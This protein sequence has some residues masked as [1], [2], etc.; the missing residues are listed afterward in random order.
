MKRAEKCK[1]IE[2]IRECIDELDKSIIKLLGIRSVFVKNAAQFKKTEEDIRAKNRVES[3]IARR[4]DWALEY[5][6]DP[7][8]IESLYRNIVAF[9]IGKEIKQWGRVENVS[10]EIQI[11]LADQ[12]DAN[13]ILSLQKRAYL[14]EVELNDNNFNIPPIQQDLES[15]KNDFRSNTVL[16]A[17]SGD[18]IVGSVR[19]LQVDDTCFIGRLIVEPIYQKKGIGRKLLHII[20][21]LFSNA[22]VF[23]LFT[24][25]KSMRNREFYKN[26]GYIETEEYDSP[27]GTRLIKLRKKKI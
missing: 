10:E 27:D 22:S 14:Q 7:E 2:E 9:F 25:A 6:L 1:S 16:K 26:A 13:E 19:A 8:F 5:G 18:H 20:E 15:I 21:E 11:S 4:R 3:M 12:N 24:G 23:E 17:K